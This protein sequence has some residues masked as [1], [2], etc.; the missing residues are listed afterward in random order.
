MALASSGV[1]RSRCLLTGAAGLFIGGGQSV[2]MNLAGANR[3]PSVAWMP[4]QRL[5]ACKQ[6]F[7]VV[8]DHINDAIIV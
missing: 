6:V 8:A 5:W 3:C 1:H 7:T 4:F 2:G